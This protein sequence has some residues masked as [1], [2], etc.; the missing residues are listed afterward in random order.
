MHN[1][2]KKRT[3]TFSLSKIHSISAVLN[4][5]SPTTTLTSCLALASVPSVPVPPLLILFVTLPVLAR[6]LATLL[7]LTII[8]SSL[9]ISLHKSLSTLRPL[10]YLGFR[11]R[12]LSR[13]LSL[14]FLIGGCNFARLALNFISS[15]RVSVATTLTR[16]PC[17]LRLLLLLWLGLW[18]LWSLSW[19]ALRLLLFTLAFLLTNTVPV[20]AVLFS[21]CSFSSLFPCLRSVFLFP[22]TTSIHSSDC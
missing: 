17:F 13:L 6:S 5:S 4:A 15:L 2:K 12:G 16:L 14:R 1:R 8:L 7:L 20:L 19:S 21:F 10:Q 9:A 22:I 18:L 11:L 3:L